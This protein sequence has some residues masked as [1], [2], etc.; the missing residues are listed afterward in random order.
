MTKTSNTTGPAVSRIIPNKAPSLDKTPDTLTVEICS[1]K[2]QSIASTVSDLPLGGQD[3]LETTSE[4]SASPT[5]TGPALPLGGQEQLESN[6]GF[7]S[8]QG[9]IESDNTQARLPKPFRLGKLLTL[10]LPPTSDVDQL[11]FDIDELSLKP[12]HVPY[13]SGQGQHS[14]DQIPPIRSTTTTFTPTVISENNLGSVS[15][16]GGIPPDRGCTTS[17]VGSILPVLSLDIFFGQAE[18]DISPAG[19]TL[20]TT[21]P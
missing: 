5:D 14:I 10:G 19:S 9:P 1:R 13:T 16:A 11:A 4:T 3:W 17:G 18:L 7:S 21:V 2:Q 6:I 8:S 15:H 20:S 12:G